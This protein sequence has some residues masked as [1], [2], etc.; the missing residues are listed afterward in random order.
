MRVPR[1]AAVV[2]SAA[3]LTT[4]L[5]ACGD[6]EI[7]DDAPGTQPG[8]TDPVQPGG[9]GEQEDGAIDGEDEAPAP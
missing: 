3:A 5:A 7:T 1:R 6:D 9:E 2:L 8:V 4:A